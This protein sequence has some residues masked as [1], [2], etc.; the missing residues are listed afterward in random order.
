ME[1]PG[2]GDRLGGVGNPS[3][4][5]NPPHPGNC[6]VEFCSE[7]KFDLAR[8]SQNPLRATVWKRVKGSQWLYRKGVK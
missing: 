8:N 2:G 7:I 6:G 4:N 3:D 5:R 1:I